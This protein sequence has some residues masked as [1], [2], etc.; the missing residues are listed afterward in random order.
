MNTVPTCGGRGE[1]FP[2][3]F[4]EVINLVSRHAAFVQAGRNDADAIPAM[5]RV[6]QNPAEIV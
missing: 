4:D 6:I 5:E 1:S 2:V 3:I